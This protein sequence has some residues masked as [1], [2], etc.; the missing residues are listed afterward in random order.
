[1]TLDELANGATLALVSLGGDK[2]LAR[3]VQKR[4]CKLGLLDPPVDGAFGPVS[5]WALAAFRERA[6]LA[7]TPLLDRALAEALLSATAQS[8]FPIRPVVS[9]AGS[10]VTAMTERNHW[11]CRHPK[12]VNIV[13]VEGVNADGKPNG[14]R[15]NAFNDMRLLIRFREDGVPEL[16]GAWEG[17]SEPGRYYVEIQPLDPRGAARIAL[18]QFK[19]WSVG[20]HGGSAPH[21]ALVQT[22]AITVHRDLNQDYQR[23][24][25]QTCVGL[26]GINQHWGFDMARGDIGKASAGCLV[27]RTKAGHREFM[28]LCKND[29]RYAVSKG[30]RFVS[31]V[32]PAQA[33]N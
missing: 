26:F 29:A 3:E 30:Y 23:A 17:T 21:E 11:L 8:L 33:L 20:T 27:G 6:G 9:L 13:Y 28:A 31:T 1:M 7:E 32:L 5:H 2:P 4:L 19:A 18:G 14:N 10:V 15:P 24:D 16:A 22:A 12:A 25:D